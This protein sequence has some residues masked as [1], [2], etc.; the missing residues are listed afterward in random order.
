[1][2]STILAATWSD[3]LF[4][5]TGQA[6][7]Q[8][9]R[10]KVVR[11]L[12]ADG[13]GGAL[14][15]VDGHSLGRRTPTGEWSTIATSEFPLACSVAA[16]KAIYVGTHDAHVLRVDFNGSIDR[17]SGFDATPGRNTWYAGT[18]LINGQTVG[19][20]LGVRS[21]AA[22][23]DRLNVLANVHVGGIP[24][25]T[26]GGMSWKPTIA[27]ESDVHEVCAHPVH[28]ELVAAASAI[29][30]CISRDGGATWITE[31]EGLHALYC[32]AAAFVGNEIFVA[33]A[34][35]HFANRGAVYRRGIG[36]EGL[37]RPLDGG[38]AEWTS[39]IVDT[40][41]ISALGSTVCIADKRGNLYV[42]E[43]TGGTW[44][45]RASGLP[46]FSSVLVI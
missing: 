16:G 42:S 28:A 34:E 13:Q 9:L 4:V 41:C 17:L 2:N 18:A 24:R 11:A 29:G 36:G 6:L 32:S 33:A 40:G 46:G 31:Q 23:A 43:D 27:V 19:P 3:G 12:A 30:L 7:H 10:G 15:I 25:S 39:G 22:T 37:L 26:D 14:A 38:F 8:E 5:E 20:P 1:M 45:R 21:I 44:S 35:D